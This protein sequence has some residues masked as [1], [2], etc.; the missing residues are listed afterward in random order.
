MRPCLLAPLLAVAAP[1]AAQQL[2]YGDVSADDGPKLVY[3]LVDRLEWS[4]QSGEDG[5]AW[6]FSALY[7][8]E[9]N[10]I[11]LSSVGEGGLGPRLDYLELQALYSRAVTPELD[12][13][14]GLRYD[15]IPSPDRVHLT[16]GGQY[17]KGDLWLGAFAYVSHKGELSARL[18][19]IYNLT[20][21][22][23]LALQPSFEINA[24]GEDI[25][26]LGIGSGF[27]YGEAGL[28]LR[29]N[30]RDYLAPYAG[31][32]WERSFGRTAQMAREAGE[33][34]EATN[35]VLGVRSEF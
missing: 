18:G 11:W 1:A 25:P 9:T 33:E 19:G 6:D 22:G 32:S 10:R 5:L 34:A 31:V 12:L 7:G 27:A 16:I 26:A 21:I 8:G 2:P 20:L 3:G 14:A 23:P 29:Y 28:R 24:Y 17:E 13:Q 4:P 15:A 30:W 35:L